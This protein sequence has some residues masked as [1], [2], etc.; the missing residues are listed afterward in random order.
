MTAPP[1]ARE[2]L[3]IWTRIGLQSFGGG[4]AVQLYAYEDLVN[5][6]GW[7]SPEGWN[8]IWGTCQVVPGI[9]IIAFAAL[10]GH[11]LAGLAGMAGS[12]AGLVVP[13][14][15]I[16]IVVAAAYQRWQGSA[17]LRGAVR[18][19]VMASVGAS[20]VMSYRFIRPALRAGR[21]EGWPSIAAALLLVVAGAGLAASGRVPAL[22][23][24]VGSGAVMALVLQSI[25]HA[26]PAP[27]DRP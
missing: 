14:I 20:F 17:E 19:L 9:N 21:R 4:Q 18:G 16:T 8:E 22:A 1:T 24:L 15:I 27:E 25:G 2:L 23:I 13:S 12:T 3:A 6:R 11:R 26:S 7:I 5:R 10:S